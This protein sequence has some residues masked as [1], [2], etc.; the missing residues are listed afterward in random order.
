[1]GVALFTSRVVLQALGVTDYGINNIVGGIVAMFA[2]MS[3]TLM[4]I[5]QRFI[6]VEMEKG[7][8]DTLQK[9]FSTSLTLHIAI[10]I[11]IIILGETAGLWFV[12]NK[13]V[14][15]A[16]RMPAAMWVYQLALFGFVLSTI[17]APFMALIVAHEDMSI[18]GY[19]GIFEAVISLIIA[20]LVVIVNADKL[21]TLAILG[22]FAGCVVTLFYNI[23]CRRKYRE[24]KFSF[25][26]DNSLLKALGGY[27]GY[28]FIDSI[29]GILR[30]QGINIILNMF[31]GPA[32]NAARGLAYAVYTALTAFG[33]NF[34]QASIPQL[35]KSYARNDRE[36]MWGLLDH[37][38]RIHYFL[39]LV[40][41]VPVVLKT[42][43][44]LELWLGNVP[45]YTAAFIRLLVITVL[46]EVIIAPLFTVVQANGNMKAFYG[47]HYIYTILIVA[48]SYAVCKMGYP[49][50]YV[51]IVPVPLFL[52]SIPARFIVL[53]KLIGFSVRLFTKKTLLPILGGSAASFIPFYLICRLLPESFIYSLA[54]MAASI[55]WTGA[56]ILYVGLRKGERA[57]IFGFLRRKM[58]RG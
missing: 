23:F 38:T 41:A 34:R 9:I 31:F 26:Y 28:V 45:E 5:T 18:Y 56:M 44:I 30:L 54:I 52:L 22:F 14:I 33:A 21:I 51:F 19:I 17:N 43:F 42:E 55:L 53:R 25:Y 6:N 20:Y 16:D 7:G 47:I 8:T 37:S 13:L 24:A 15:P 10:G 36:Y 35:T 4:N 3:N 58:L 27:G 39:V 57:M 12:E 49:P 29:L 1:M 46:M 48:F 50:Y 32:V 40:F 11:I 2:F